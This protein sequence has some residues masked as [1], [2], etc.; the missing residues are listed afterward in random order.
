[1]GGLILIPFIVIFNILT[2]SNLILN[3]LSFIIHT[4]EQL[5]NQSISLRMTRVRTYVTLHVNV[6]YQK[7]LRILRYNKEEKQIAL[8]Q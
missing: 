2:Y 4:V 5:L 7:W 6:R 1:M 3:T 8:T